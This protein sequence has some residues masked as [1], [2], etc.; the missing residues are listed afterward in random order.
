MFFPNVFWHATN[1]TVKIFQAV[2]QEIQ[3]WFAE[4]VACKRQCE[5]RRMVRIAEVLAYK[6][7]Q[8]G[9]V[10]DT[11]AGG[12]RGHRVVVVSTVDSGNAEAIFEFA[13]VWIGN[14]RILECYQNLS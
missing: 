13:D 7:T 9:A 14:F 11:M 2:P 3:C 4:C 10:N 8:F 6:V 1:E 12:E 5:Q